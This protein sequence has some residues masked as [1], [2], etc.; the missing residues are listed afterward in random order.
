MSILV[1]CLFIAALLPYLSKIPVAYAMHKA[2]GYDNRYPREQQAGL[3]GFGARALAAH[4]NSFESL[5][6]FATAVITAIATQHVTITTQYLAVT[7]IVTRLLYHIFYLVNL[8]TLRSAVW[9]I[10]IVASLTILWQCIPVA[11]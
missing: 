4:Q 9:F 7:Y 6:V 2:N 3:T 1:Y 8:S 11:V 10:G 5:L